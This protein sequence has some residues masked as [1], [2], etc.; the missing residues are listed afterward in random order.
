MFTFQENFF[1]QQER[2]TK[3][4]EKRLWDEKEELLRK[5][6]IQLGEKQRISDV[7]KERQQ[8][9]EK[10]EQRR[11]HVNL[12][13]TEKE[14]MKSEKQKDSELQIAKTLYEEARESLMQA[15]KK[16]NF[17]EAAIAQ[18]LLEVA[19]KKMENA[20][21]QSKQCSKKRTELGKNETRR[22]KGYSKHV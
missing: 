12:F 14:L 18:G 9:V 1:K 19:K 8:E 7:E 21:D 11:L 17:R 22:L 10:L 3:H 13:E 20:M 6:A 2:H 15:I 16:K 4:T 5:K